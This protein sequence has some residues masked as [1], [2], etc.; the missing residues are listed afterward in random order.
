MPRSG[1]AGSY[2]NSVFSFLRNLHTIFHSGC[3]NLHSKGLII[4]QAVTPYFIREVSEVTPWF[5][6]HDLVIIK[7]SKVHPLKLLQLGVEPWIGYL[8]DQ[9][10]PLRSLWEAYSQPMIIR[11]PATTLELGLSEDYQ[12]QIS[13][14]K[15]HYKDRAHGSPCH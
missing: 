3:T 12:T 6:L 14:V 10:W 2:G 9:T 5:C 15:K 11:S 8:S 4:K 7:P 13:L 1:I